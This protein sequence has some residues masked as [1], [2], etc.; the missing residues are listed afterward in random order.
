[1]SANES[2]TVKRVSR[3]SRE[4]GSDQRWKRRRRKQPQAP[5][6]IYGCSHADAVRT[7][8]ENLGIR[9]AKWEAGVMHSDVLPVLSY[10]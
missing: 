1:M 8:L 10:V 9:S 6:D 5:R 7:R 3:R 4:D 2:C